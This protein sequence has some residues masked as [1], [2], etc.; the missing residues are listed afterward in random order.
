MNSGIETLSKNIVKGY[1]S[2]DGVSKQVF[3]GG[4]TGG[5]VHTSTGIEKILRFKRQE[6]LSPTYWVDVYK[7]ANGLLYYFLAKET[8]GYNCMFIF[9]SYPDRN[10]MNLDMVPENGGDPVHIG[11]SNYITIDG[12]IW[13]Y[14]IRSFSQNYTLSYP[15]DF[16]PNCMLENPAFSQMT[17]LEILTY[18]IEN[19][20]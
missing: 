11:I 9:T 16:T 14:D 17:A 8:N 18:V 19:M 2:V 15:D 7:R 13:P 20:I 12:V 5:T 6:H 10:A 1:A 4:S 3:G